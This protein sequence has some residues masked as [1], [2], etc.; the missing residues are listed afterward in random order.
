MTLQLYEAY[1]A[2]STC[3]DGEDFKLIKVSNQKSER[4]GYEAV[5]TYSL[6]EYKCLLKYIEYLRPII[7]KDFENKNVFTSSRSAISSDGKM[8]FSSITNIIKKCQTKSGK[9]LTCRVLR[10]SKVTNSRS[11]DSTTI[12]ERVHVAKKHGS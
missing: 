12:E 11:D 3:I 7:C 10:T 5:I 2:K 8:K 1:N 6:E 4:N 9:K